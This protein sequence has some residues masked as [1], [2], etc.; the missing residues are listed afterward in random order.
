M[1]PLSKTATLRV[2]ILLAFIALAV[3]MVAV[4][5]TVF[6]F[7]FHLLPAELQRYKEAPAS[8]G[9]SV[10]DA[11]GV[12]DM[13]ALI[14][15]IIGLLWH[16]RWARVLV[17]VAVVLNPPTTTAMIWF[18]GH[19][20]AFIGSGAVEEGADE[21]FN[22]LLGVLL[23]MIWLWMPEEFTKSIRKPAS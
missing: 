19:T 15:G 10:I 16:R 1:Q 3:R 17:S 11:V 6:D 21:A 8:A 7:A 18:A 23:A 14:V 12:T 22:L 2:V 9:F 4:L 5:Y 13:I 20:S